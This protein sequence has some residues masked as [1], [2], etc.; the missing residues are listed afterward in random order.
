LSREG[1]DERIMA[2]FLAIETSRNQNGVV[3]SPKFG[4]KL[5]NRGKRELKRLACSINFDLQVDTQTE[6]KGREGEWYVNEA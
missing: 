5:E 3:S 6:E 1:F 4:S 2:L